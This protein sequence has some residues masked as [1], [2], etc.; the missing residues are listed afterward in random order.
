MLYLQQ[1]ISWD[2]YV[3]GAKVFPRFLALSITCCKS[4]YLA[5]ILV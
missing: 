3:S 2:E 4:M 5:L 1:F